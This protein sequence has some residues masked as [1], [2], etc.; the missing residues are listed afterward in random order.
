[1]ADRFD[2]PLIA[3]HDEPAQGLVPER[4]R[5]RPRD[6]ARGDDA[7]S[8]LLEKTPERIEREQQCV[9]IGWCLRHDLR[10]DDAAA[11]RPVVDDERLAEP[12]AELLRQHAADRVGAAARRERDDQAHRALRIAAL[13]GHRDRE[14]RGEQDGD[15]QAGHEQTCGADGTRATMD[16]WNSSDAAGP[17]FGGFG[18]E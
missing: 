16:H 1:M 2:Q 4:Q 10:A 15:G 5:E 18:A 8:A 14:Q 7:K 13:R 6:A 11:R 9:A 3:A 17:L 12:L